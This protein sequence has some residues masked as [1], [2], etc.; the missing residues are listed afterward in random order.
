MAPPPRR[1]AIVLQAGILAGV[2]V[3]ER[4]VGPQLASY[5]QN[6]NLGDGAFVLIRFNPQASAA[7]ITKFLEDNKA[8]VVGGP[9]AGSG[10]FRLRVAETPLSQ[11]E[12]GAVVKK[13]A[14]EP[15]GRLHGAGGAALSAARVTGAIMGSPWRLRFEFA[16]ALRPCHVLAEQAFRTDTRPVDLDRYRDRGACRDRTARQAQRGRGMSMGSRPMHGRR[17][18]N[19]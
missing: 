4:A 13:M 14:T 7:D 3:K 1:L 19:A 8:T 2:F 9:A 16:S 10:L 6:E 17:L 12:L 5:Q 15:G 11:S 18:A